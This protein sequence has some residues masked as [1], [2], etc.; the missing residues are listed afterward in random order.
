MISVCLKETWNFCTTY[1][2]NTVSLK[3]K[4]FIGVLKGDTKASR[5]G[6]FK[7][8]HSIVL[9]LQ[10]T[11][12]IVVKIKPCLLSHISHYVWSSCECQIECSGKK[13]RLVD[14]TPTIVTSDSNKNFFI[15]GKQ[16][17][18]KWPSKME[19]IWADEQRQ[20]TNNT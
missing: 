17:H 10:V 6:V 16:H 11:A 1:N 20:L 7:H 15:Q 4:V 5:N 2:P 9:G 18:I 12:V 3:E 19:G 14:K 8:F 13:Q